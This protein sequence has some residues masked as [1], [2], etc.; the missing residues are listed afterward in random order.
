MKSTNKMGKGAFEKAWQDA[1]HKTK[2]DPSEQVWM[3]I[4]ASLANDQVSKYRRGLTY[5][6]WVAAAGILLFL[7]LLGYVGYESAFKGEALVE[8]NESSSEIKEGKPQKE[9]NVEVADGQTK[10]ADSGKKLADSQLKEKVTDLATSGTGA[11]AENQD[12]DNTM[13][14]FQEKPT[15]ALKQYAAVQFVPANPAMALV[16]NELPAVPDKVV[17]IAVYPVVDKRDKSTMWAGINMT[18]GYFDP[19]YRSL[20]NVQSQLSGGASNYGS[21]G[22][23]HQAGLSMSFGMEVGMS[24]SDRWQLS[25]GVQYL[26]SNVQSTTN[27]VLN[28]RTPV[29]SSLAESLDFTGSQ[30]SITYKPTELD[31]TFQFL[32]IPIQ[33]GF[34]VHDKKVKLLVNA[35]IASD[36]FLRNE[37]SPTDQ[38]LESITISPGSTA[39][40][41]S[42]YFNGL[43]GAQASYA[44]LPRY[45]ITLEP[46]YKVAIN[47]FTK[48]EINYSSM[49]SS[50]GIGVGV[51]YV[52]K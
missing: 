52:F 23:S 25:G 33:A 27:F 21:T 28:Q 13:G 35:G 50:F 15:H 11:S 41:K 29:F 49:P 31:N 22:E 36:I 4:E 26:N 7:A 10:L 46:R 6:K 44:F 38:S 39:P 20:T 14:Q 9:G 30:S 40:F 32:S 45:L 47:E 48:S 16:E 5:Y 24:L 3:G 51:K 1:F 43:L 37:I 17:G 12:S 18:P 8:N 42:V 34:V 2:I 19:N